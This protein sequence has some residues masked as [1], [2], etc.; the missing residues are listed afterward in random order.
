[1]ARISNYKLIFMAFI[2]YKGN[3]PLLIWKTSSKLCYSKSTIASTAAWNCHLPPLLNKSFFSQARS[4]MVI[5]V[6][7]IYLTILLLTSSTENIFSIWQYV[8]WKCLF[9]MQENYL[10]WMAKGVLSVSKDHSSLSHR[11]TFQNFQSL[12]MVLI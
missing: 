4:L 6:L 5:Q 2:I 9:N 1:M 11:Y 10:F 7:S 12:T 3:F 8:M